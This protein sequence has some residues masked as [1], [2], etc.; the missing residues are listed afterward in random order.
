MITISACKFGYEKK[1]VL[2]IESF[3]IKEGEHIFL[4]GKS[5][6][7]KSTFLNLLCAVLD[8]TFGD[9][10][11]L[12]TKL[13]SLSSSQKD[14]FRADNYGIIFQQFNL[15]PYLSV[16]E[17]ISLSYRFSKSKSA[18]KEEIENLLDSLQLFVDL[19]TPAMKLSLGQQQRVAAARA[20]IGK[21]K[22]ILAD[23]PTSALDGDTKESFMRVLFNQIE[24]QNATLI[25]VS[26]DKSLASNFNT[27]YDF[28]KL[29]RAFV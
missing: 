28:A 20:L 10:E 26:H 5:G 29:N 12:G 3:H 11:V 22:I 16:E 1:S 17:N 8:P 15:L 27:V 2:D 23:E 13:A 7:A 25:F 18:A 14:R 21:P 9:I 19:K 4:H 24:A 6:S